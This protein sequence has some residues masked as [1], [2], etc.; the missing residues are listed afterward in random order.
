MKLGEPDRQIRLFSCHVFR[1]F[2]LPHLGGLSPH[3]D[4]RRSGA[5]C[6]EGAERLCSAETAGGTHAFLIRLCW[7]MEELLQLRHGRDESKTSLLFFFPCITDFAD[8]HLKKTRSL[9][10]ALLE[11]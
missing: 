7:G 10:A 9:P 3:L 1:C 5:L 8:R 11:G 6:S 2:T 4:P